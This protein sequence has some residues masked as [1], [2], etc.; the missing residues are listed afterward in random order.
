MLGGLLL[1]SLAVKYCFMGVKNFLRASYIWLL[2][3]DLSNTHHLALD[4]A[5]PLSERTIKFKG[6]VQRKL[7]GVKK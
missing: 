5:L 6:I 1:V 7:T 4:R 2:S 3:S